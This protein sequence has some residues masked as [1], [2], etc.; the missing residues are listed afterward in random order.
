MQYRKT[1]NITN[2][3]YSV[4][5]YCMVVVALQLFNCNWTRTWSV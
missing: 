4:V 1:N 5:L 3:V 2:V